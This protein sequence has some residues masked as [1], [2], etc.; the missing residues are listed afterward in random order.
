M[1]K[2][3][4]VRKSPRLSGYDYSLNGAYF[5]TICVEGRHELLGK[6]AV[7]AG[8]SRP[9]GTEFLPAVE[10]APAICDETAAAI[11]QNIYIRRCY[12]INGYKIYKYRLFKIISNY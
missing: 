2:E 6:I 8:L 3:L 12:L 10:H 9:L 7:G 5:I 4:P 11:R 1:Q